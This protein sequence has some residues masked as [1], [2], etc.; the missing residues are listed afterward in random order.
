MFDEHETL[1]FADSTATEEKHQEEFFSM[2]S[3]REQIAHQDALIKE[4]DRIILDAEAAIEKAHNDQRLA[5]EIKR[6]LME[7]LPEHLRNFVPADSAFSKTT[8]TEEHVLRVLNNDHSTDG[9]MIKDIHDS[10]DIDCSVNTVVRA[11]ERLI[12][13]GKVRQT[14]PEAQ[15]NK[16]YKVVNEAI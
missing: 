7:K 6:F 2:D 8:D 5:E 12:E 14:N 13:N 15:R 4:S 1:S 11:L 16:R 3:I 9:I 10:M